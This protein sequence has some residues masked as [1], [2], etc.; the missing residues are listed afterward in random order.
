M[1]YAGLAFKELDV[2]LPGDFAD[3]S[4][5]GTVDVTLK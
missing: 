4:L 2:F 3:E 1:V 5:D